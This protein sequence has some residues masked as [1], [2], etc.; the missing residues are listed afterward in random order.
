MEYLV[1]M[2]TR[3]PGGTSEEAIEDIRTRDAHSRALAPQGHLLRWRRPPL[4]PGGW[5]SLGLLAADDGD[6]L[7]RGFASM[8]LRVWLAED[9]WQGKKEPRYGR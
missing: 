7:E 2:A 8:P 1:I 4:Q 9:D 3:V 5:Q 6:E